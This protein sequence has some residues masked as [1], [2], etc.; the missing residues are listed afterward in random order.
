MIAIQF[1][2][3][4]LVPYWSFSVCA[5]NSSTIDFYY[6][7]IVQKTIL[8]LFTNLWYSMHLLKISKK[9][10]GKLQK[11]KKAIIRRGQKVEIL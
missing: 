11:Q 2:L 5:F 9:F 4:G 10:P 1:L 8:N 7:S 3:L 6:H